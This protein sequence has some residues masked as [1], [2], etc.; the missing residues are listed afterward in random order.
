VI[1]SPPPIRVA[2]VPATH[3]YVRRLAHPRVALV[4]DPS[5]DDRRTPLLLDPD[6][7][8]A[9]ADRFDLLHVHFGYEY[10]EPARLAAVCDAL[11][12]RGRGLVATVHDLR[13]PNHPTP[14]LHEAGLAV[15]LARADALVTLTPWAAQRIRERCGRVAEVLPHPHVVPLD[16][17]RRRQSRPRPVHADAVRVGLHF[18]SLRPNMTGAPALRATLAGAAE[19]PGTRVVVN[20]HGDVLDPAS[21]HHDPALVALALAAAGDGRADLHVHAYLSDDELWG[22]LESVDAVV[23]P[24]RFG[25]HSGWMEAAK[26][27]GTAVIA[28]SCGGYADQG[29]HQVFAADE[30]GIDEADLARAV[31]AAARAGRPPP[32]P[33]VH[34][35]AERRAVAD[36]HVALYRRVV[37]ADWAATG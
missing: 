37:A 32:L 3:V 9:N 10:Y 6:W 34:R 30:D 29:A 17:L 33:A 28:P 1:A 18:K 8:D 16:E 14:E 27:L 35:D 2:S 20:L 31:R 15:W 11:Q 22:Y 25:T 4:P 7:V 13:N 36:A 23:L 12:R 5:G 24:Y 19:V 21:P 26:D